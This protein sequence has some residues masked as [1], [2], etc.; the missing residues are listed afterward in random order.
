MV[1]TKLQI[2][3]GVFLLFN[4]VQAYFTPATLISYL[5]SITGK[6]TISG[7]FIEMGPFDPIE[8]IYNNTGKWLGLIGGDYYWYIKRVKKRGVRAE[9]VGK[10]KNNKFYRYG[11]TDFTGSTA[12]NQYAIPYWKSGGI[13]TLSTSMPNPTTGGPLYDLS[14][15]NVGDLLL[16]GTTTNTNLL[17]ILNAI[18]GGI[19]ELQND[20]VVVMYRP[21]H[22]MNGNWF[23]WGTTFLSDSQFIQLW[24]F[25]H[26]YF[27]NTKGL[28]NIVW[29]YGANTGIG[30]ETA[31]YAGDQY[32]DIV[33]QDLYTSTPTH[34]QDTYNNLATIGKP[35][36]LCEFGSGGPSGGDTNFN[37]TNLIVAIQT[38]MPKSIYWQQWWDEDAGRP[39]W[40]MGEMKDVK[41]ALWNPWV[42]NR[43]DLAKVNN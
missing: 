26:D 31:R 39:G 34:G 25:T 7:Q 38:T 5:N 41:E 19:A 18:A 24:Q 21:F 10:R 22:E 4:V 29:V 36:A 17:A 9:G 27:T 23:W 1:N 16:S 32:V 14:N 42:L 13:I 20:G 33:G 6:N 30:N 15:L 2:A 3:F 37:E 8:A 11:E 40:G 43:D 28:K 12:F 35:I